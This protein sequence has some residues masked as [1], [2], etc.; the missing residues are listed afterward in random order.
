[1]TKS[2][3]GQDEPTEK[4]KLMAEEID[5]KDEDKDEDVDEEEERKVKI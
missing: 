2:T 5:N 4:G 1:M 3:K